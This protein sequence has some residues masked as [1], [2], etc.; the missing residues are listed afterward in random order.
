MH[1]YTAQY[2][3]DFYYDNM[4]FGSVT[5]QAAASTPGGQ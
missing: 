3:R 1:T 2:P 5:V 4:N